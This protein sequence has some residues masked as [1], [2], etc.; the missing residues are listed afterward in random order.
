MKLQT[1]I[2]ELKLVAD[3]GKQ[4]RRRNY[5]SVTGVP[6]VQKE[7]TDDIVR[8]VA[9]K[10]L[11]VQLD[12]RSIDHPHLLEKEDIT[13]KATPNYGGGG[14]TLYYRMSDFVIFLFGFLDFELIEIGFLDFLFTSGIGFFFK[15]ESDSGL[16]TKICR[17]FG[18]WF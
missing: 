10:W 17:I 13:W 4:Y 2:K 5:L 12:I 7:D 14:G 9:L 11:N 16:L 6:E 18:Y 3:E 8:D 1:E 15:T